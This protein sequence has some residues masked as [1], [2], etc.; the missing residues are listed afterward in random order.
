MNITAV[1][2]RRQDKADRYSEMRPH[3]SSSAH[4]GRMFRVRAALHQAGLP[5]P[6]L[7]YKQ[8]AGLVA[9][10]PIRYAAEPVLPTDREYK[11]MRTRCAREMRRQAA[12]AL[13]QRVQDGRFSSMSRTEQRR[14]MARAGKWAA[15][16]LLSRSSRRSAI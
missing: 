5:W 6:G 12:K 1:K 4:A 14:A 9:V 10:T 7:D 2:K 16:G 8:G 3:G 15:R 11:K 13:A